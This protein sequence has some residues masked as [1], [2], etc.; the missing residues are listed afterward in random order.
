MQLPAVSVKVDA[1]RLLRALDM[2]RQASSR[3]LPKL[4]KS[5]AFHVAKL[6]YDMTPPLA[7][8]HIDDEMEVDITYY[9]NAKKVLVSRNKRGTKHFKVVP[10]K[11][12]QAT[13]SHPVPMGVLIIM[14]SHNSAS[15]Y[16]K[17]TD[18]R[19]SLAGQPL[20]TGKGTRLSRQA[21]IAAELN[22][23]IRGRHSSTGLLKK[24]WS[25]CIRRIKRIG[26]GD[27]VIDIEAIAYPKREHSIQAL[28]A[29]SA[30]GSGANYWIKIE[31][32]VGT[33][34]TPNLSAR[35]N[36]F[37]L[38]VGGGYLNQAFEAQVSSMR[39]H[40]LPKVGAELK[41]AWEAV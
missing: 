33:I 31:N 25:D 34:G 30:G 12:F 26:F 9:K 11:N 32:T 21:Q 1:S 13:D 38:E 5:T 39:S 28:S 8:S 3:S 4:L 19:W 41:A 37:L 36:Y 18:S 10:R 2:A 40:Y 16:N 7:Q 20:P 27:D 29:V 24:G 6:A 14:A 22:R 17:M 35:R 23:M 15:N